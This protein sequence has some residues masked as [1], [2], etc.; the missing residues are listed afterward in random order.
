MS[1]RILSMVSVRFTGSRSQVIS[2]RV[3]LRPSAACGA[4]RNPLTTMWS[5]LKATASGT[6]MWVCQSSAKGFAFGPRG[7]DVFF[8]A[9]SLGALRRFAAPRLAAF[10]TVRFF[11]ARA[12]FVSP[13]F[14]RL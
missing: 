1:T 11:A 4:G 9:A 8:F 5:R 6:K 14:F 3:K 7:A 13:D 10:L 2:P 12:M